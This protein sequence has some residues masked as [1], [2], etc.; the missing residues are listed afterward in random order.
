M[1]TVHEDQ[2]SSEYFFCPKTPNSLI[3]LG[4]CCKDDDKIEINEYTQIKTNAKVLKTR[5]FQPK[6]HTMDSEEYHEQISDLAEYI[7]LLCGKIMSQ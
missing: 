5:S 2:Y 7:G 3:L 1:D 4:T 6:L